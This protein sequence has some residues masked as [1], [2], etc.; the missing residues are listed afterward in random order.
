MSRLV[1]LKGLVSFVVDISVHATVDVV[2][3][4]QNRRC[5]VLNSSNSSSSSVMVVLETICA[6]A[7]VMFPYI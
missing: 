7:D 6:V 1:F 5:C 4:L 2:A 3:S